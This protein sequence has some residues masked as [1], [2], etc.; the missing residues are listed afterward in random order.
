M[1]NISANL[2]NYFKLDLLLARSFVILRQVFKNRFCLFS[3]GQLWDDSSICGRNYLANVIGKNKKL[4]LT[5]VQK[6]LLSNGDS[7]EWDLT[8][9]TA[10]LLNTERPKTLDAAQ[11]QQLDNEDNRLTQLKDIRNKLAHHASKNISNIEFHQLWS[12]LTA[13]LVFFGQVNTELDKLKD[14]SVFESSNQS[15]NEAN[16]TE[17]LRLNSLGTQAHK[18]QKFSDAITLFTKATVLTDVP[19]HQHALV[20]SNMSASRLALY[21]Q[22]ASSMELFENEDSIDQRYHALRDAKQARMLSSTSWQGHFRVGKA[23][24][25]LSEHEKAMSSFQRALALDPTNKKIQEAMDE[26]RQ[27]QGRMSRYEHLDPRLKP[28]TMEE[29][30]NEMKEKVGTNPQQVRLIHTLLTKVDPSAADVVKG[31]KYEHS[32]IDVKQDYEQAAKYFAKAASKGNAEGIYNLARLTDRGL[33]VKKDHKLALKLFEQ[34][35]VQ[36]SQNP[37]FKGIPNIGVAES[38]HALGLRYAEGVVVCKDPLV[39]AQWYQRAVDHGSAESANNLALMYETGSGVEK[40]LETAK[41]LSELSARRGDPNAMHSLALHLLREND[42]EMSKIWYN[43]ACEAGN[44]LAKMRRTEFESLLR[45]KQQMIAYCPLDPLHVTNEAKSFNDLLTTMTNAN[46]IPDRSSIYDFDVLNEHAKR[47]SRTAEKMCNALRHFQKALNILMQS[48]TLME[49]QEYEFI[50]EFSQCC[51]IE[52]TVGEIPNTKMERQIEDIVER[53][54][55]RCCSKLNSSI[56]QLDEDVRTCYVVLHMDLPK[57][58]I[59]FLG[60]CKQKY[61]K[62]VFFLEFSAAMSCILGHYEAALYD[63][64]AGLKIYP[65]HCELLYLKAVLLSVLEKDVGEILGAYQAFLGVAPNDHSK[66]PES[67]YAISGCLLAHSEDNDSMTMIKEIYKQG[68]EAE[69]LQLPCF[70]PYK[71]DTKMSLKRAL[72]MEYRLDAISPLVPDRKSRLTDPHRIDTFKRHREWSDG[73]SRM[74]GTSKHIT[75]TQKPRVKQQTAKSL[76]GLKSISLKEINPTKDHV[77]NGY[78]LSVT[79]ID[80]A[81]TWKPSIHL[82]IEDENLNCEHMVVYGFSETEGKHLIKEVFTIGTKM[83]IINP[84]LRLGA[85]DGKPFIRVDDFSSIIMQSEAERVVN[86]CRC[87]GDSNASHVCGKC[88]RARYCTKECQVMDWKLYGHKLIC[89]HQ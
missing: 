9:L 33:G 38:E 3:G 42:F 61:P 39:A 74:T 36:P 71:S 14:D 23:Y 88:K 78:V 60:P 10:L 2:R 86:M 79:I 77:Y 50:H 35:A 31:H 53:V 34:A 73:M 32:D 76:V 37:K 29:H 51:R 55:Q 17:V 80:E 68:E 69:K 72:D 85:N 12:Q 70:L 64:R 75:M 56:S 25:A 41:Q 15:I 47:G 16:V 49:Q 13:I 24:A 81:L 58:I 84:Y 20:Y 89:E 62:S 11:I 1:S 46:R 48:E 40:N 8:M 54:R 52:H 5:T 26:S 67:Y 87:C 18:E 65:N 6:T 21:D 82:I 27:I 63:A 83:N 22:Q 66:V 30:L 7:N 4:N 45:Q 44:V 28:T 57:S 43:R 59:Q 19:D